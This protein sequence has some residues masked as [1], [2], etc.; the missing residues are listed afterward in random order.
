MRE[1][2]TASAAHVKMMSKMS[3]SEGGKN[4]AFTL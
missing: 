3:S 4:I 1:E 2:F